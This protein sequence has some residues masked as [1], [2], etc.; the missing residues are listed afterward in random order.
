VSERPTVL[1]VD[2]HAVVRAGIRMLLE[3]QADVTVVAEASSAEDAIAV[4]LDHDPDVIVTDLSMEGIRGASVVE[5]FV[6]RFPSARISCCRWSTAR[7]TSGERSRRGRRATCSREPPQPSSP[8]RCRGSSA[9]SPT[10]S[11]RWAC[12]SPDTE[13]GPPRTRPPPRRSRSVSARSS[14]SSRSDTRIPRS[15]RSS[16]CRLGRSSRTARTSR[17]SWVCGAVR[18]SCARPRRSRRA[19]AGRGRRR[20]RHTHGPP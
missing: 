1:L 14:R 15:P 9:G 2:D 5:A 16:T 13:R 7:R 6:D 11:P 3:S 4:V 12:S 18:T 17:G 19:R 20:D 10:C 8:M